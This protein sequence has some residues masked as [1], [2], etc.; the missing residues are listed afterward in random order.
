MNMIALKEL[1][2]QIDKLTA[3]NQALAQENSVLRKQHVQLTLER[4][5]LLIQKETAKT[6][7]NSI[8]ERIKQREGLSGQ[9]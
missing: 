8:I 1:E 3:H 2:L 9:E 6:H 5:R 7:L 4:N